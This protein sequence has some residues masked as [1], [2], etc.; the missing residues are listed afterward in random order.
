MEGVESGETEEKR[1]Q[2]MGTDPTGKHSSDSRCGNTLHSHTLTKTHI[3]GEEEVPRV[4]KQL[5]N[6]RMASCDWFS[7]S[8]LIFNFF[9]FLA[10]WQFF[11]TKKRF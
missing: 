3:H 10:C 6:L 11:E 2:S 7:S 9:F 8:D 1:F 4:N 5:L